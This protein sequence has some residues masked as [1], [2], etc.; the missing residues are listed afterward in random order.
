MSYPFFM[1]F[2][3]GYEHITPIVVATLTA[4]LGP[5]IVIYFKYFFKK[6]ERFYDR[7]KEEFKKNIIIQDRVNKSISKL[8][9]KYGLDRIWIA[10]FHNGGNFYPGGKSMK[11]LSMTFE[12]TG[13][14]IATDIMKFQNL[15]VSFLAPVLEPLIEQDQRSCVSSYEMK[16]SDTNSLKSFFE[17]RGIQNIYLFA[18]KNIDGDFV[19]VLGIDCLNGKTLI[20]DDIKTELKKEALILS[21]YVSFLSIE[22][23]KSLSNFKI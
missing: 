22:D 13:P 19:G 20:T 1:S 16:A 14:G 9:E 3:N 17:S 6:K 23:S 10:Q 18:V 11:K 12:Q 2:I 4:V 5:L 15:P 8:R 21:G 7:R